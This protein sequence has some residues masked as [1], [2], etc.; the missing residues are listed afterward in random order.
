MS[1]GASRQAATCGRFS[2]TQMVMLSLR[3]S[4]ALALEAEPSA[5]GPD[6]RC[7]LL[8]DLSLRVHH[9]DARNLG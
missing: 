7:H 4:S 8:V 9:Q 1:K 2:S 6:V 3:C 5:D